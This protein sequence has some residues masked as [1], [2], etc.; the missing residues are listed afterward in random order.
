MDQV[1]F[2]NILVWGHNSPSNNRNWKI[3][4]LKCSTE[5]ERGSKEIVNVFSLRHVQYDF[6][7]VFFSSIII[8]LLFVKWHQHEA[9]C[10][11]MM[12]NN[13]YY[14]NYAQKKKKWN[15]EME[16]TRIQYLS[17]SMCMCLFDDDWSKMTFFVANEKSSKK[18]FFVCE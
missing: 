2:C 17:L 8:H 15:F 7:L 4:N 13:E 18:S 14:V 1:F 10:K 9:L 6:F 12:M 5:Y 3:Y 11:K 16:T